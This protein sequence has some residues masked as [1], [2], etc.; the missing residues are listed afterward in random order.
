METIGPEEELA[1]RRYLRRPTRRHLSVLVKTFHGYVWALALRFAENE[2]DASDIAQELFLSLLLHP[3]AVGEVRSARGYLACRVLTLSSHLE[4][5]R[6]RRLVRE[7][8]AIKKAA[9]ENG[10]PPDD[11]QALREA[12]GGLPERT[13][14][15]I[16]YR[17]LAGL[18][19]R[20]IAE[21]L[22]VSERTVEDELRQGR[23][24]LRTRLGG[25]AMACLA[26]LEQW[27]G[28]GPK[29]PPGLEADLLC[30][31]QA[32]RALQVPAVAALSGLTGKKI[33]AVAALLMLLAG[34]GG[35]V[36]LNQRRNAPLSSLEKPT[37]TIAAAEGSTK[38]TVEEKA[39]RSENPGLHGEPGKELLR[40]S[41]WVVDEDGAVVP[42]AKV[43]VY[44]GPTFIHSASAKGETTLFA[45]TV[46]ADG[47]E[48]SAEG[49]KPEKEG[50]SIVAEHEGSGKGWSRVEAR[51]S[52]PGGPVSVEGIV[53]ALFSSTAELTGRVVDQDA[54]PVE[55]ASVHVAVQAGALGEPY[56]WGALGA[57]TATTDADGEFVVK[58]LPASAPLD[59]VADHAEYYRAHARQ[60]M[61]G[62][63]P[64]EM[65]LERGVSISGRV[66]AAGRTPVQGVAVSLLEDSAHGDMSLRSFFEE[67]E[68]DGRFALAGVPLDRY[69]L[70]VRPPAAYVERSDLIQVEGPVSGMEIEIESKATTQKEGDAA[71]L[72]AAST[73]SESQTEP[74]SI[75]GTIVDPQGHPV[76]AV[77][78]A[79]RSAGSIGFA[80][81]VRETVSRPDGTFLIEYVSFPTKLVAAAPS[82]ALRKEVVI[83]K[84]PETDVVVKMEPFEPCQVEGWV[85]TPDGI[86]VPGAG[87]LV[88]RTWQNLKVG[89]ET[90]RADGEGRFVLD[91]LLPDTGY[92]LHA[93]V[94]DIH[95]PANQIFVRPGQTLSVD[96]LLPPN[97]VTL[98][99]VVKDHMGNHLPGVKVFY[100]YAEDDVPR[101]ER[102]LSDSD[103]T[104][105]VSGLL[106]GKYRVMVDE[107]GYGAWHAKDNDDGDAVI[108]I[109]RPP[110]E[111]VLTRTRMV[112]FEVADASGH[113]LDSAYLKWE[114]G[115][116]HPVRGTGGRFSAEVPETVTRLRIQRDYRGI[117]PVERDLVWPP[118]GDLDLGRIELEDEA[119]K[120]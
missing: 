94:G 77:V 52:Q 81:T 29:A 5:S 38:R 1:F 35:W 41:G 116:G 100:D 82:R 6:Q 33:L 111:I 59:V 109:P 49:R 54:R 103:G 119:E 78:G 95:G 55:G 8:R 105:Q 98:S 10:L 74:P 57:E 104:F 85:L 56:T 108:V 91:H 39:E 88:C 21:I 102:A 67:T 65:R 26:F 9:A 117:G 114:K 3:P 44:E 106:P 18:R 80:E 13:R 2:D 97:D 37:R 7:A 36:A 20:E 58:G 45:Q 25:K 87:V 48:F 118:T 72:K 66:I 32:G 71:I 23:E 96:V 17:Y 42:G 47:G 12:I 75:R 46:T 51:R 110:L 101:E 90:T 43:E 107:R 92:E 83:E 73:Q 76:V 70:T 93:A 99:G 16:E 31:V 27:H 69:K 15:V 64:I 19:N 14:L 34:L 115:W 89:V 24:D 120:K 113:L 61:A 22:G 28:A 30:I 79:T 53:V 86:A 112:H 84:Q 63:A 11:L 60:V 4:R 68:E 40:I 62:G 50:L